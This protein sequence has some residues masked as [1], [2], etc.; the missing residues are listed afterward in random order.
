MEKNVRVF[1][2]NKGEIDRKECQST[3]PQSVCK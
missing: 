1:E 2:E 3:C